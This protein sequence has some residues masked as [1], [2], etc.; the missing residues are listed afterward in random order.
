M[1]DYWAHHHSSGKKIHHNLPNTQSC[2]GTVIINTERMKE[3]KTFN[4]RLGLKC[5]NPMNHKYHE[6]K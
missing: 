2:I 1:F 4:Q 3:I 6:K 5:I